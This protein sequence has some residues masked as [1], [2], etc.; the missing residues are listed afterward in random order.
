MHTRRKIWI[1][2]G[3][4][5][6]SGA[7]VARSALAQGAHGGEHQQHGAAQGG[8]GGEGG[9]GGAQLS[10]ALKTAR[11]FGLI[12]GHLRVGNELVEQGRWADA[13]PHVLHPTEEIYGALRD[14]LKALGIRPFESALKALAQTVKAKK[15]DAYDGALKLVDEQLAA[16]EAVLKGREADWPRFT[17][18]AALETLRQATEEYKESIEGG[19]FAKAVEYQDARGFVWQSEAMFESVAPELQKRDE[20]ALAGVRAQFAEL[21]K[22]WPAA[23]PPAR[24]IKDSSAVYGDVARIEL[25]AGPYLQ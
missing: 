6:A 8:E 13:L 5:V 18:E 23:V 12:R 10:P 22:A 1:G 9:E 25:T 7:L 16:G 14:E 20:N 17:V 2:L 19:R 3:T 21:K 24:P 4:A 15:R 11:G